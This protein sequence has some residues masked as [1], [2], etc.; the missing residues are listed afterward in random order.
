MRADKELLKKLI[1]L[2]CLYIYEYD[3]KSNLFIYGD[4]MSKT[5]NRFISYLES[6]YGIADILG[7]VIKDCIK[8]KISSLSYMSRDEEDLKKELH[9]KKFVTYNDLATDSY[10]YR[11]KR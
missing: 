9:N 1:D 3:G 7:Y 4:Y 2:K 8:D 5:N 6:S 10:V 11:Y